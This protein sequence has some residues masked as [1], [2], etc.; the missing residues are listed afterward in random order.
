LSLPPRD[1]LL[2]IEGI[3]PAIEMALNSIG[4]QRFADFGGHSPQSLSQALQERTGVDIPAATITR[5]DWLGWAELLAAEEPAQAAARVEGEKQ[6]RQSREY[7]RSQV[8]DGRGAEPEESG[9]PAIGIDCVWPE[10]G[11][12]E[13]VDAQPSA[14]EAAVV[15]ENG[16]ATEA[17]VRIKGARF[18]S[19]EKQA[20]AGAP[21][22]RM[23]RGEIQCEFHGIEAS[24]LLA[25]PVHLSAQLHAVHANTGESMLLASQS[26]RLR[27]EHGD[28]RIALESKLP[29]VGLYRLQIIALLL[30][31]DSRTAFQWGPFLRVLP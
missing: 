30:R 24:A 16:S 26:R 29:D 17:S 18:T 11:S 21:L 12:T 28:Y 15:E 4:I 9:P 10:A 7:A 27:P 19:F 14:T 8:E 31:P 1:D 6:E 22:T 2:L 20:A 13:N 5:L 25:E 23:L 3:D